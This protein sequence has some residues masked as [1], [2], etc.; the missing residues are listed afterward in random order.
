MPFAIFPRSHDLPQTLAQDGGDRGVDLTFAVL[1]AVKNL[2]RTAPGIEHLRL[3]MLFYSLGSIRPGGWRWEV[4]EKA[5]QLF[6]D[7]DILVTGSTEKMWRVN[8]VKTQDSPMDLSRMEQKAHCHQTF[9]P[10]QMQSARK[11][12]RELETQFRKAGYS[13]LG[14]GVIDLKVR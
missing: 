7:T 9:A 10:N 2:A 1:E 4:E 5:R 6:P 12:Y 14:Y 8:G 3:I 11:G 13:H